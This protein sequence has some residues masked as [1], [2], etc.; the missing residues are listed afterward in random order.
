MNRLQELVAEIKRLEKELY[1]ELQKK[2]DQFYYRVKDRRVY[3]EEA[4]RRY[5]KTLALRLRTYLRH[6][7][8]LNILTIPFIWG[9]LIPALF[10]DLL[11]SV[12]HSVCFRIYKIPLVRRRDYIVIDR[13]ALTYLNIIEKINC[14][15]C[16]YFNGLI[17][18]V[19]EIAAR[20]EQYWCPIKHA[21]RQATLHSRY[22]KFLEYGDAEGFRQKLE[23]VRHDFLD[24]EEKHP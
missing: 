20:T 18:Y 21:R 7:S 13:H 6:S 11:V 14:L 16:G 3:F 4:T 23:E 10:L 24:L 22:Q 17:S 8:L 12:F 1:A 15:Y 9:C 5:H 2:Q 19:Q